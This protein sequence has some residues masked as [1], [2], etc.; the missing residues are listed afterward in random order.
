MVD[1]RPRLLELAFPSGVPDLVQSLLPSDWDPR[2]FGGGPVLSTSGTHRFYVADQDDR[3]EFTAAVRTAAPG[4][5]ALLARAAPRARRMVDTDGVRLDLYLD[6]LHL[7]DEASTPGTVMCEVHHHPS[8]A[9]SRMVFL[10]TLPDE[11]SSLSWLWGEGRLLQRVGERAS[12]LWVTEARWTGRAGRVAALAERHLELP[13]A[14]EA[15]RSCVPGM[16]ID[17]IELHP[18][19]TV[20]LTPGVLP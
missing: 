15:A 12:V 13:A 6:D 20:D 14:W 3:P 5:E 11:L 1:V 19:G 2:R 7:D 10:E 17:G 9:R 8:G 18:D 4:A 16:Y